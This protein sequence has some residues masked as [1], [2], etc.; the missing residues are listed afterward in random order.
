MLR[1]RVLVLNEGKTQ[2][3]TKS[4]KRLALYLATILPISI[5]IVT[6]RTIALLIDLDDRLIYFNS[7]TLITVATV[8]TVAFCIFAVSYSFIPGQKMS[9]ASSFVNPG[10]YIPSG[11]AAIAMLFVGGE[12]ISD[13]GI[14]EKSAK[15]GGTSSS[16]FIV[17]VLTILL[18]FVCTINFFL[19]VFYEKRHSRS[20]AAFCLSTVLFLAFY[21]GYLF[22]STKLPFN[23]PNKATDQMTFLA[24]S[25]FFL[26]EARIS[27]GRPCWK[28]Y[29]TFGMIAS[30]LSLFSSIPS[31]IFYFANGST[32]SSIISASIAENVLVLIL[33]IYVICRL[34]LVLTLV[35]DETCDAALAIKKMA[36]IR[37]EEIQVAQEK[38]ETSENE[39]KTSEI[40]TGTPFESMNYEMDITSLTSSAEQSKTE[41]NEKEL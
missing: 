16:V 3:M 7:G 25:I 4:S 14:M 39:E 18:A 2:K 30:T 10:T 20:R 33:G 40:R 11:L 31:L 35:P 24:L 27:L 26:Y 36:Q 37:S 22:F 19:N 38:R 41:D 5:A 17:L 34:A 1:A 8:I 13:L 9:P 21:A 23:S 29:I 28:P 32:D 6:L 12:L 15:S